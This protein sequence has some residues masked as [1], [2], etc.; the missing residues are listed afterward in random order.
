MKKKK[1][2]EEEDKRKMQKKVDGPLEWESS[3]EWKQEWSW[4][5]DGEMMLNFASF[6]WWQNCG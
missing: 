1:V 2:K 4:L 5:Q 3:R 6:E